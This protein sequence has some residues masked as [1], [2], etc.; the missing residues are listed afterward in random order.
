[1]EREENAEL[2]SHNV[3]NPCARETREIGNVERFCLII[4]KVF[5]A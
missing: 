3:G 5:K 4:I 1:M 2:S